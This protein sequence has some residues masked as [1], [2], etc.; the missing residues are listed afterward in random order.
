MSN[1][2]GLDILAMKKACEEL[3]PYQ[4]TDCPQCGWPLEL[5]Q[6]GILHCKFDGWTDG[7]IPFRR[8]VSE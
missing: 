6:D 5:S 2:I 1:P 7:P 8:N 3:E 4:R